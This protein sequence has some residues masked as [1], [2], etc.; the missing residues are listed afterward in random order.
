MGG[1]LPVK[2]GDRL[3]GLAEGKRLDLADRDYKQEEARVYRL[4]YWYI[5]FFDHLR[6]TSPNFDLHVIRV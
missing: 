4:P 5:Y 1:K 3:Q 6:M 2:M